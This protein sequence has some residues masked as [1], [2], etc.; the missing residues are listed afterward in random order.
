MKTTEL[1][2]FDASFKTVRDDNGDLPSTTVT[3]HAAVFNSPTV[4]AGSFKEQI[5]PGAFTK[6]LSA[7]NDIRCLFDHNTANILGR[8]KSGTLQLSEDN[9]GLAFTVNMPATSVGNDLAISM[10]RGDVDQC[11]FG[12]IP[13]AEDWD[14]SDPNMPMRTITEVQLIEVSI[15]TIP[16]YADTNATLVGRSK[17]NGDAL[18]R[19][20]E[21]RKQIIKAIK[22]AM[23]NE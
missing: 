19:D 14:Y 16:A 17:A 20:V 6:T 23:E 10:G 3:G 9:Q 4:I 13:T 15:V 7:N 2:T 18:V 1:R 11:S 8:T 5:A 21:K 22:E 12:F